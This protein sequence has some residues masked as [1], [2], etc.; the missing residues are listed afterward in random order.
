MAEPTS[1][2]L[3]RIRRD[4]APEAA[5][6]VLQHLASVPETLAGCSQNE[7]RIQAA[8]VLPAH[9]DLDRF[10]GQLALAHQDWRDLLMSADL[11]HI[12]WEE[13]LDAELGPVRGPGLA[14]RVHR[15]LRRRD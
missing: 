12:G 15:L 14:W 13:R 8:L 4:F 6:A 7:E 11:G 3:R 9:G 5:T 2:L 10:L 1:R